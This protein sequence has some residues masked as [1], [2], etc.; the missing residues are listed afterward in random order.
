MSETLPTVEERVRSARARLGAAAFAPSPREALLLAA[1]VLGWN[2]AQVIARGREVMPAAAAGRFEAL[3][4]RR[5]RGEP[6]AYLLGRREFWGRSFHVDR[7]VL[8]PRPETEHLVEAVLALP[9]PPGPRLLD[10]GTGSGILA[11]TLALELPL[12]RV[13][14]TDL[15]PSALAVAATNARGLGAAERIRF[16]AADGT[17]G[18]SLAGFDLLVSNPPYVAPEE[19]DRLSHEVTAFEPALALWAEEGGL[20]F[21]RRLITAGRSLG[22]GAFLAFEI[23]DGQQAGILAL[24]DGASFELVEVRLDYAGKPRVVVLKRTSWNAS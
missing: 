12:A 7:R 9:L 5:L 16:V 13:V 19:R 4:A 11:V 1:A 2:E 21:F 23:G 24:V 14:A 22:P 3:L 8:I 17:D 18:L 10:V 6:V 20:A 15:S